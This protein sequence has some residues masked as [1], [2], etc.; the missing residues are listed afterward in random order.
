MD[1]KNILRTGVIAFFFTTCNLNVNAQNA[2]D[3]FTW[4]TLPSLPAASGTAIQPGVAGAFSGVD[5][6]AMVVAGGAN[7]PDSLPWKGGLKKYWDDIFVFKFN[8]E[9]SG[10]WLKNIFKLPHPVAYGVSISTSKGIL[11]IGG[12]NNDRIFKETFFLNYN[13]GSDSINTTPFIPLP[14]PLFNLSAASIG[15]II[16]VAGGEDSLTTKNIF[17]KIDLSA[18]NPSWKVLPSWNGASISNSVLVAQSQG[19]HTCLYLIGGKHQNKTDGTYFV[20]TV[21]QFDPVSNKW[22]SKKPIT[23][24]KNVPVKIA[25]GTGFGIGS[26]FIAFIGGNTS[27]LFDK[28]IRLNNEIDSASNPLTKENYQQQLDKFLTGHPGFEKTIY[29]YN[30][31][32]NSWAQLADLPYPLPVT[33][34]G[35]KYGDQII[36]PSGEMRP[37]VRTTQIVRGTIQA[38]SHFTIIDYVVLGVYFLF[39]IGI[40]YWASKRQ[41]STNDYFRASGRI[42]SWA[43]G[44]SIFGTQLSAITFMA[45]PAKTFATNWSYFFLQMTILMAYPFISRF[46]IPFYKRLNV[47]SAYEYLQKRFNYTIRLIG[48]LLFIVL[49]TARIAIVLL[50]PS[51]ALTI[52]TGI[53]VHTCI[54][55]MGLIT[56]LYTFKGGIEA[57]VWTD[58]IQ[59]IILLGGALLCL[60][61]I[62]FKLTSS[63]IDIWQKIAENNKLQIADFSFDFTHPT[64]WVM[65]L[66]GLAINTVTYGSDQTIVQRYMTTNSIKDARR[67]LRLSAWMTI[68]ATFI[69][70]GIGTMLYLFYSDFPLDGNIRLK[71]QDAIFPWFIVSQLPAGFIGLLIAA[72]FAAAMSTLSSSLNSIATAIITDIYKPRSRFKSD[73]HFLNVAQMLTVVVGVVGSSLALWMAGQGINS[74]MGSF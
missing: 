44:L 5:K 31:I 45:I 52:V 28:I 25:A 6:G 67:G 30:T 24:D 50:L 74:L 57:V 47:T 7:F 63:S 16:Y 51:L 10:S 53:P 19:D 36:L 40:G 9:N 64:I 15:E 55:L 29:L 33:L 54:L 26:N 35:F 18:S 62:P 71:S 39:M 66:G 68:P 32:T 20:S 56:I 48:S 46:F 34:N 13:P 73:K 1:I 43:V 41:K 38:R 42:P 8:Q 27:S 2:F 17:L 14:E 72:V 70:F 58:V 37:G 12:I 11:C 61:L 3:Q 60:V 21:F 22:T 49:Q 65:I 59:V 69:F 23:N 4:D